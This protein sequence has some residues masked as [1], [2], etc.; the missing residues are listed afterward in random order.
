MLC[1]MIVMQIADGCR[2]AFTFCM[3]G[4][5]IQNMI[6]KEGSHEVALL[7]IIDLINHNS[8]SQVSRAVRSPL[9][10]LPPSLLAFN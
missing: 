6:G 3:A 4:A 9:L 8:T 1:F 2:V 10:R 5:F 7:P